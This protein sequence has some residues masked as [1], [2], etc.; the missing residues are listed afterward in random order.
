MAESSSPI[1]E[2]AER[3]GLD[4]TEV[5][6][7]LACLG[8]NIHAVIAWWYGYRMPKASSLESLASALGVSR[9]TLEK[10]V[11]EARRARKAGGHE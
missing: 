9:K 3:R 7:R 1:R 11:G 2:I 8:V 5:Q 10:A 6:T 4:L